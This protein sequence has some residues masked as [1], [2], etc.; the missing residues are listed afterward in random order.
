MKISISSTTEFISSKYGEICFLERTIESFNSIINNDSYSVTIT[1]KLFKL[2]NDA[3]GNPV[4]VYKDRPEVN[5]FNRSKDQINSL[6]TSNGVQISTTDDFHSKLIEN[7]GLIVLSESI[8][9]NWKGNSNYI[10]D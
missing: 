3:D 6:F 10:L 4:R 5:R 7:I 9:V 8:A 1:D 2:E